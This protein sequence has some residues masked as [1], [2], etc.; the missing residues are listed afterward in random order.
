MALIE[1]LEDAG[2]RLFNDDEDAAEA[3]RRDVE[4]RLPGQVR[5][6]RVEFDDGQVKLFGEAD[7][8]AV[9]TKAIL[10]AGNVKGVMGV[11][12]SGVRIPAAPEQA[13]STRKATTPGSPSAPAG[14]GGAKEQLYEIRKGDTLSAIAQTHYGKASEWRRLFE[15]NR[16]IIVDPDRIYPGQKIVIPG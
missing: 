9:R 1:F 8:Q 4:E 11:D 10:A 6:L 5:D 15:A 14:A 7:S 12:A 13:A 3:I 2:A 16:E